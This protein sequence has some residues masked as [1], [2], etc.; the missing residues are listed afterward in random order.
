MV[1]SVKIWSY[2]G[3]CWHQYLTDFLLCKNKALSAKSLT[4]T[5]QDL[6]KDFRVDSSSFQSME[7]AQFDRVHPW[8]DNLCTYVC[9]F[10]ICMFLYCAV[11]SKCMFLAS[12]K[13]PEWKEDIV[14][15][16]FW[17]YLGN[18]FYSDVMNFSRK[19]YSVHLQLQK[20]LLSFSW[21]V[22]FSK[23]SNTI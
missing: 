19:L 2:S 13:H 4:S 7:R 22:L 6:H 5:M 10:I 12:L 15:L 3:V 23:I 16:I 18:F 14:M 9:F 11:G 21:F 20:I 8:P 17:C 1:G